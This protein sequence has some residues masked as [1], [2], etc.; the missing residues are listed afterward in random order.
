ME[1]NDS[2][3]QQLRDHLGDLALTGI[4]AY[5]AFAKHDMLAFGSQLNDDQQAEM[6][7]QAAREILQIVKP[8]A[9]RLKIDLISGRPLLPPPTYSD[10]DL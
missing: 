2:Q 8:R 6:T 1:L 7:Y 9:D 3:A 10:N 5:E 4:T